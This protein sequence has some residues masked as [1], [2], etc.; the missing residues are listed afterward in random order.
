MALQDPG[1]TLNKGDVQHVCTSSL[2]APQRCAIARPNA[3]RLG[4]AFRGRQPENFMN[5]GLVG[6]F[7]T[8]HRLL[9]VLLNAL[10][11]QGFSAAASP[12]RRLLNMQMYADAHTEEDGSST[13]VVG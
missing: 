5:Y 11:L 1:T 6:H 10:P 9:R 13:A 12:A 7:A 4:L 2:F 8:A 3:A